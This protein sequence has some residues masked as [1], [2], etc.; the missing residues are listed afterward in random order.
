MNNVSVKR[1]AQANKAEYLDG[2]IEVYPEQIG[3]PEAGILIS[4]AEATF[5]RSEPLLRSLAGGLNYVGEQVG[6]AS[7]LGLAFGSALY[8]ALLGALHGIRICEVED[9][10]VGEFGSMLAEFMPTVGEAARDLAVRVQEERYGESQATLQTAADGAQQLL[11]QAHDSQINPDFPAYSARTLQKG[12]D[13]G[14]G[15][16]DMAALIKVLRTDT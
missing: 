14:L 5:Q 7:A 11:K 1:W 12:M 16:Q 3:T 4:G 10:D 13:S 15:S 8:G 2:T 6:A 9:L